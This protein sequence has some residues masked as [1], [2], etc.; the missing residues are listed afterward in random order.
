VPIV[1]NIEA[2]VPGSIEFGKDVLVLLDDAVEGSISE[3]NDVIRRLVFGGR[4]CDQR[5][6]N[7]HGEL[8]PWWVA[9]RRTRALKFNTSNTSNTRRETISGH[10]NGVKVAVS[11]PRPHHH[12]KHTFQTRAR[13][14]KEERSHPIG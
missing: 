10:H 14:V 1:T 3:D 13:C 2:Y 5:A 8:H 6:E 11:H 7:H 9:R 4:Q 12:R